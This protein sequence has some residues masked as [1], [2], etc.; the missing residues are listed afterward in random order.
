MNSFFKYITDLFTSF[1]KLKSLDGLRNLEKADAILHNLYVEEKVPGIAVTLLK[2]DKVILQK[3]YGY[4][5]LENK[6]SVDPNKTIFRIA[7]ISKCIT[8]LTLG[9]MVEEGILSFDDSFYKHV[10]Y[11]PKKKY[12]FTLR[13]LASHTAGIRPYRGK[14]FGLNVS[15]SIKESLEVFQN[16][17]L[18]FEPGKGYLYNSF[19]FV[20]LSL[21]MQEASGVPFEDYVKEKVLEPIGMV[22]TFPPLK[23]VASN[24]KRIDNQTEFYTKTNIGFKRAI[25]V[26]NYYKLAG[27]GYLATSSDV[28][29]LGQAI[30]KKKLLRPE[31]YEELLTSQK[32][33]GKPT[34]YGLGFQISQDEK[35]RAYVGHIG[36]SVGAYSNLFVYP[37]DELVVSILIN[38]TDAK[39]QGVLDELILLSSD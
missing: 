21:A 10:P 20:L 16:D 29:K 26:N 18:V 14:E 34:Y 28:A 2:K 5:D 27:G 25:E 9:K 30:L 36:S 23:N 33:N 38:C 31:T 19:D 7:S 37:R 39:V 15:Y 1:T 4:S 32:I 17:P 35:G 6:T 13:Q 24:P 8:G 11:Y 3:G 12:D 22:N